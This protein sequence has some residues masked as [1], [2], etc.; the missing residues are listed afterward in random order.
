MSWYSALLTDSTTSGLLVGVTISGAAG[1]LLGG[2]RIV[3]VSLGVA[4]AMFAGIA[5][6]LLVWQGNRPSSAPPGHNPTLEFLRDFGLILFVYAIG[7]TVGPGFF[8]R[9]RAQGLRWN[10]LAMLVVTLGSLVAAGAWWLLTLP[11]PLIVGLLAG[12]TTNTPSLAAASQALSGKPETTQTAAREMAAAG[13]AITYPLGIIGII[14]TLVVVRR[15]ARPDPPTVRTVSALERRALVVQKTA[16]VGMTLSQLRQ[17]AGGQ[18]LISRVARGSDYVVTSPALTLVADDVILAVGA[19]ADL[20]ALEGLCGS[21]SPRDLLAEPSELKIRNMLVSEKMA[22]LRTLSALDPGATQAVT[23]TRIERAGVE[24][25]ATEGIPLQLGDRLRV[26]GPSEAL[27]RFARV[28]GNSAPALD[29]ANLVPFFLGILLGV[30]LGSIPLAIPGLPAALKLGLAGGPLLVALL[31]AARGRLGRAD[32]YLPS[33]AIFFMK[34]FGIVLFLSCVGLL[35]GEAFLRTISRPDGFVLI[36]IGVLITTVPLMIVAA[37]ALFWKYP[38]GLIAGLIAGGMTD[39]PALAFAQ[40]SATSESPS[41]IYAT[42]Y[43]LTMLA[44]IACAQILILLL[45]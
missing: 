45:S 3:G 19:P 20:D 44:R 1:M 5:W 12:A 43:P 38:Y 37:L 21:R 39:P 15:Y 22:A 6:D 26:V 31:V 25:L 36:G 42:V 41:R 14:M 35:S 23:V 18:V 7:L 13:Y 11:G 8:E 16:A 9:L 27:E 2:V 24:L 33:A 32:V 4:G 17:R 40:A 29:R 10:A 30:V 34:E 28:V